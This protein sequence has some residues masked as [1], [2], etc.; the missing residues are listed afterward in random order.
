MKC[1]ECQIA[2]LSADSSETIPEHV[3]EHTQCCSKCRQILRISASIMEPCEEATPP[4]VLDR[5]I[6]GFAVAASRAANQRGRFTFLT[7]VAA[8][9]ACF[10]VLMWMA[11]YES[12]HGDGKSTRVSAT[13]GP[14]VETILT[15]PA[16][17]AWNDSVEDELMLLETEL[18]VT[19]PSVN[20]SAEEDDDPVPVDAVLQ[21]LES[22]LFME[23]EAITL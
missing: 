14:S 13:N 18:A 7:R 11:V 3:F 8:A 4:D 12:P 9:A 2:I 10:A 21:R 1:N 16:P 20:T 5:E 6:V 15:K 22:E 19:F 23:K 17:Y